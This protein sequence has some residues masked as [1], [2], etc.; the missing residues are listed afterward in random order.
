MVISTISLHYALTY[1]MILFTLCQLLPN[2][3]NVYPNIGFTKK[4]IVFQNIIITFFDKSHLQ[5]S[6]FHYILQRYEETPVR[7]HFDD[8]NWNVSFKSKRLL[9]EKNPIQILINL[10]SN[11]SLEFLKTKSHVGKIF[12]VSSHIANIFMKLLPLIFWTLKYPIEHTIL[13]ETNKF[14]HD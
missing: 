1:E 5:F 8:E 13:L 2:L 4:I 7:K 3:C 12:I 14:I 10:L 6:Y 11:F 9:R